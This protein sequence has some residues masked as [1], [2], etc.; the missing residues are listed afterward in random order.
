MKIRTRFWPILL[1][2]A[3]LAP[4]GCNRDDTDRLA[5][6]GS[7]LAERTEAMLG[8][9]QED[10]STQW[11][12]LQSRGQQTQ[13]QRRVVHRLS[14]EK[15]LVDAR[16]NVSAQGNVV[17]LHGQVRNLEQRRRAVDLAE[18]TLGVSKVEEHLQ[19]SKK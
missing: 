2:G 9:L 19:I 4:A 5:K 1:A 13:L 11:H 15:T 12:S 3:A 10:F 8:G 17:E 16:I 18:S 6:I 7:I 14:Q